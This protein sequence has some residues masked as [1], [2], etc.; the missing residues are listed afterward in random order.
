MGWKQSIMDV[1]DMANLNYNW[2]I[3]NWLKAANMYNIKCNQD[4]PFELEID[5]HKWV[6]SSP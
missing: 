1:V 3:T 4:S 5:N 6:E 2:I